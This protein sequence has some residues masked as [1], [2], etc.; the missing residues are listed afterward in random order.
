MKCSVCD[1]TT[2]FLVDHEFPGKR[3]IKLCEMCD[4]AVSKMDKYSKRRYFI[5]VLNT[6]E[7]GEDH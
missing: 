1:V 6:K 7:K 5:T 3:V 4:Y 2:D